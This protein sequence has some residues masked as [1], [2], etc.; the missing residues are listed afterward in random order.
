MQFALLISTLFWIL[1]SA[2]FFSSS[3][4]SGAKKLVVDDVRLKENTV[5]LPNLPPHSDDQ[6][7]L[8]FVSDGSHKCKLMEPLICELEQRLRTKVKRINI[9]SDEGHILYEKVGGHEGGGIPFFYNRRTARAIS[10]GT[11]AF[12]LNQWATGQTEH[13]FKRRANLRRFMKKADLGERRGVGI[14]DYFK[15]KLGQTVKKRKRRRR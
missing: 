2:R 5:L 8:E 10:G 12:N 9:K 14:E 1:S 6:Y 13:R 3:K 15:E 11:T 7:L 4:H